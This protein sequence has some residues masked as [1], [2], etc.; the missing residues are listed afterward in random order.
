MWGFLKKT[1]AVDTEQ[2][3]VVLEQHGFSNHIE[4]LSVDKDGQ[5]NKITVVLTVTPEQAIN[6][7]PQKQKATQ[8]LSAMPGAG[9]VAVMFTAHRT[10]AEPKQRPERSREKLVLPNIKKIVAVASGKGGVG[11]STTAVNL[12]I[13][14]SQ[15]GLKVGLVDADIYGPSIPR[16]LGITDKPQTTAD[17]KMIPLE[18]HGISAMSMGFL[19]AEET[20]MVWR[21][22]MVHSA[23]QQLF[24]DVAWGEKDVLVID[25]PPGTGDAQLTLTQSIPLTGAVIV[26]TPQDIALIDARKGI[27]MFQKTD[28]PILGLVENMSFFCCPNCGHQTDIFGHGGAEKEAEKIDVPFLGAIALEL[29]IRTTSDSGVPIATQQDTPHA[30]KYRAIAEVLKT[31]LFG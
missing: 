26:S 20:P 7:E 22:P 6:L 30:Q 16:M 15:L 31:R 12:A 9:N 28:V 18:K 2:V 19:V 4:S 3:R 10:A 8:V 27:A 24:R 23:I 13:A 1:K 17:K 25:L 29:D 5:T 11:K 14:L 21:G